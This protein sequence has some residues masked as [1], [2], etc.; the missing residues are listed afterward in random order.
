MDY[1]VV[2]D[3]ETTGLD[4][5]KDRIIEIGLISFVMS[6][7]S[8]VPQIIG[9]YSSLQDPQIPL[10]ATVTKITGLTDELV[11]G[12][13]IDWGFVKAELE[14]ASIVIAH[15]AAFDSMF[16]SRVPQLQGLNLHWACTLRHIDWQSKGFKTK[17][18]G[19][20]AADNGFLNPFA[21]RALFDC[22]TTF[23]LMTPHVHEL[24]ENS[25]RKWYRVCATN[26]PFA[27][28][29]LLKARGYMWDANQRFWF[30]MIGEQSVEEEKA[31]LAAE[32]YGQNKFQAQLIEEPPFGKN[33]PV[34]TFVDD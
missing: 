5:Q 31:F 9:N 33:A 28:K 19:H 3:L 11:R 13:N 6:D 26:S 22:A 25:Y 24:V 15:N 23:R 32:V 10:D 27:T 20:L 14:R 7:T 17:N 1:G 30:K 21:H 12:R 29:D 34:E 18:L 2:L 8:P 16:I 4:W